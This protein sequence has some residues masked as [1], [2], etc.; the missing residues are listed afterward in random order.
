[1]NVSTA[2]PASAIIIAVMLF[3][4]LVRFVFADTGTSTSFHVGQSINDFGAGATS[5]SFQSVSTGGQTAGGQSTSTN[6]MLDTGFQYS[7]SFT[8]KTKNWRW[9]DDESSE[10][11]TADLEDENVAPINIENENEIKLRIAVSETAGHGVTDKKFRLQYSTVSD[12]S[13]DIHDVVEIGD[14][15]ALSVWCYANGVDTDGDIVSTRLLTDTDACTGSVGNGCGTHN[16]SGIGTNPFTHQPSAIVEYEFTLQSSGS[17]PSQIY[18]FRLYDPGGDVGVP[19]DTGETY[20]SLVTGGSTLT[21][22]VSGYPASTLVGGET[23]SI[24]STSNEIAFGTL[25]VGTPLTAA[26]QLTVSTNASTGYQVFV[27]EPQGFLGE[28]GTAITPINATNASPDAWASA[29]VSSASGCW[30]YHTTEAVLGGGSTRFAADDTYAQFAQTLHEVA[31]SAVPTNNKTTDIVYKIQAHGL[32]DADTYAST[33]SY[34][35]VPVF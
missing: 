8:P 12:F 4:V 9:Y 17:P 30:G 28:Q 26:Q 1:M 14:C 31:Y 2:S 5:S 33:V 29:C 16:E 23:T 27:V 11:P 24:D 32:Q 22:S 3:A 6:F 15:T 35:V 7:E 20:P 13:A 34:I 21:F 18:F 25:P 19:A 10:T